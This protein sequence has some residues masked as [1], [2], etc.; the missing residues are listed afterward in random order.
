MERR[1][2]AGARSAPLLACFSAPFANCH[3]ALVREDRR[4]RCSRGHSFDVARSGYINL[5]QTAGAPLENSR[6]TRP[7]QSPRGA[8]C[9]IAVRTAPLLRAIEEIAFVTQSDVALDAGCGDGFYLGSHRQADWL[10]RVRRRH[11]DSGHR[12]RGRAAIPNASGSWATRIAS[13]PTPDRSFSLVLSIT[14]RMNTAEF[15]RVLRGRRAPARRRARARRFRRAA[16][17][18]AVIV[19]SA[20]S[21]PLPT[22]SRS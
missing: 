12:R 5:L 18:G 19:W 11:F 6:A 9:T 17:R 13:C 22:N 14:A 15:R 8:A 3:M 16:R 10:R 2:C 21:R 1:A 20:P 7:P 4:L